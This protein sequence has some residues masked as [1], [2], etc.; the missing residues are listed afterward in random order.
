V[1][2]EDLLDPNGVN[3]TR[4]RKSKAQKTAQTQVPGTEHQA[5]KEQIS[6]HEDY[7]AAKYDRIAAQNTMKALRDRIVE[8]MEAEKVRALSAEIDFEDQRRRVSTVLEEGK[9]KLVS[10]LEELGE[11]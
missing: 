9:K 6:M 3:V 1:N 10:T 2:H 4:P 5:S 7:A 8:R 11:E